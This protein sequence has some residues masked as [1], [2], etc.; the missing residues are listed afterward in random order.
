MHGRGA[1]AR[2]KGIDQPVVVATVAELPLF[3]VAAARE[4]VKAPLHG[5]DD[6]FHDGI[7][8]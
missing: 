8:G 4:I 6:A 2:S 1:V 5:H 3:D 7:V